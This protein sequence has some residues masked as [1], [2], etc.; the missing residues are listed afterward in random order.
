MIN[1]CLLALP[2]EPLFFVCDNLALTGDITVMRKHTTK[3]WY[4][5][6]ET[7]VTT[8]Y[9]SKSNFLRIQEDSETMKLQ[10]V[11][12]SWAFKLMGL[13]FGKNLIT[14]R[15]LPVMKKEWLKPSYDDFEPRNMWSLYNAATE[16]LKT[17]PPAKIMEKH[18][19]V[20]KF[21]NKGGHNELRRL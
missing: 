8:I 14:P 6:E 5:L 9:R 15:Q 2:L 4:D 12:N 20:H 16:A 11:D 3:V 10:D 17:A 21:F 1:Q 13:L 7:I 18:I 19:D